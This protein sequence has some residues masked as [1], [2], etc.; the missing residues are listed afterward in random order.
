MDHVVA[1]FD[2]PIGV[3]TRAAPDVCDPGA[4]R[5]KK[6]AVQDLDR[7]GELDAPEPAVRADHVPRR[8]RSTSCSAWSG[9]AHRCQRRPCVPAGYRQIDSSAS[10]PLHDD[11][12]MHRLILWD[13]DGTLIRSGKCAREWRGGHRVRRHGEVPRIVMSGKTD[14]QILQRD[15]QNR[16][17]ARRRPHRVDSPGT[18]WWRPKPRCLPPRTSRRGWGEVSARRR[19]AAPRRWTEGTAGCVRPCS[20]ATCGR[21]RRGEGL[22]RSAS[23]DFFDSEVGRV[24]H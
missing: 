23:R 4:R 17:A 11:R 8:G 9:M 22:R 10:S 3:P 2:E 6:G 19:R 12:R 7:P 16:G 21:Q 24:R 13:I 18:R 20:P 1:G 15:L 14:P 5:R